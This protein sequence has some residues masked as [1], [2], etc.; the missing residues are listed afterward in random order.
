MLFKVSQPEKSVMHNVLHVPQMAYNLFSVRAAASRGNFKFGHSRCWIR[1]S[2]G[3]LCGMGVMVNELYQL[4]CEAIQSEA[5][6]LA[7][8]QKGNVVLMSGISG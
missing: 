2:S 1:D 8:A 4:D 3:R 5:A 6:T 7:T